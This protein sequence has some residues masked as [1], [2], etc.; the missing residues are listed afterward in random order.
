MGVHLFRRA[1]PPR[2]GSLP[3]VGRAGGQARRSRSPLRRQSPPATPRR[4]RPQ[5]PRR[6]HPSRLFQRVAAP[7]SLHPPSSPRPPHPPAPHPSNYGFQRS[8]LSR[9]RRSQSP[10]GHRLVL[11]PARTCLGPL[12]GLPPHF[13]R[14]QRRLR[15]IGGPSGPGSAESSPHGGRRRAEVL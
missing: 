10:H 7:P 4:F 8:R 6:R 14:R 1:A 9:L 13:R 3:R 11:P 2:S 5:R 15:R 12:A